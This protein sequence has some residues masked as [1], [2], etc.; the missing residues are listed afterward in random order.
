MVADRVPLLCG[1]DE[2]GAP[3]EYGWADEEGWRWRWRRTEEELAASEEGALTGLLTKEDHLLQRD[4]RMCEDGECGEG[5]DGRTTGLGKGRIVVNSLPETGGDAKHGDVP[6]PARRAKE[7]KVVVVVEKRERSS[8]E[9]G[10]RGVGIKYPSKSSSGWF[11]MARTSKGQ[12]VVPA[13]SAS[14]AGACLPAPTGATPFTFTWHPFRIRT[15][16]PIP[17]HPSLSLSQLLLSHS[18][19]NTLSPSP[20]SPRPPACA[21]RGRRDPPLRRL[22]QSPASPTA[23]SSLAR[24]RRCPVRS[25]P[26]YT[27]L[28]R[29]HIL[30]SPLQTPRAQARSSP[31]LLP[32]SVPF[33]AHSNAP[34]VTLS[35]LPQISINSSRIPTAYS[36]LTLLSQPSLPIQS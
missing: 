9:R 4:C 21:L 25:S 8:R 35:I 19:Q 15:P 22:Q 1:R 13:L 33:F 7:E 20:C 14:D 26:L 36:T 23:S 16:N 24:S 18:L 6:R 27:R 17:V 29:P 11:P 2:R 5:G 3:L 32:I 34:Q 30:I 10:G 31:S 28:R 12:S